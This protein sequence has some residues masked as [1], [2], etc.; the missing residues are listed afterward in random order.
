MPQNPATLIWVRV[1][2]IFKKKKVQIAFQKTGNKGFYCTAL[3]LFFLFV[4]FFFTAVARGSSVGS[5]RSTSDRQNK[6]TQPVTVEASSSPS[7]PS[8]P[9][10]SKLKYQPGVL[11][12]LRSSS[13]SG[14]RYSW[15]PAAV[16][17]S[18]LQMATQALVSGASAPESTD[19]AAAG[20]MDGW[21]NSQPLSALPPPPPRLW[22]KLPV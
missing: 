10:I 11:H 18:R 7:S 3:F 17:L 15:C 1:T 14:W 9:A 20:W 22:L 12:I 21:M 13:S 16:H 2:Q 4:C 8:S 19:E 6:S 5:L